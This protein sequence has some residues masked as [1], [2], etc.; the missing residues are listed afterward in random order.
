MSCYAPLQPCS[1][2]ARRSQKGAAAEPKTCFANPSPAPALPKA[3]RKANCY[4]MKTLAHLI[5][6]GVALLGSS[7]L[8]SACSTAGVQNT[9]DA[10]LDNRQ[11]RMDSR[12][13]ARQGRWS[14]RSARE[15]ARAQARFDSW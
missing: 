6:P 5:I 7:I 4:F 15:D 8:F 12:T 14:E 3:G 13:G 2:P 1:Q 11:N 9:R 10:G